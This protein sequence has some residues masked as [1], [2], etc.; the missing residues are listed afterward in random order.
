MLCPEGGSASYHP[1]TPWS[2]TLAVLPGLS[3]SSSWESWDGIFLLIWTQVLVNP[4]I[5]AA[6]FPG[7]P[8]TELLSVPWCHLCQK[9]FFFSEGLVNWTVMTP[10]W[11][12]VPVEKST[13]FRAS[14]PVF[15]FL[16]LILTRW[17]TL[18]RFLYLWGS[19]FSSAKWGF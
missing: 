16:T 17:M 15:E 2:A 19:L 18:G 8:S 9:I 11:Q 3:G 4:V 12:Y 1:H 7:R 5:F 10:N 13:D 6:P 14:R